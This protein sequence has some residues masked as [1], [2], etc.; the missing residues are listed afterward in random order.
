MGGAGVMHAQCA[1]AAHASG[2]R[3]ARLSWDG[4]L[5]MGLGERRGDFWSIRLLHRRRLY[6]GSLP[7]RRV[8]CV[9]SVLPWARRN[10]SSATKAKHTP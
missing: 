5:R 9:T 2:N 1:L 10:V 4:W 3:Q 8:I 6:V 7:V